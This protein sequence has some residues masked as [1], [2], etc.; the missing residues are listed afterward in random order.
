MPIG[1]QSDRFDG[2]RPVVRPSRILLL[3]GAT[4]IIALCAAAAWMIWQFRVQEIRDA[5]RELITLDILLIEESERALQSVDL[6]LQSLQ[7]KITSDGVTT[8][9]DYVSTQSG[10]DTHELLRSKITGIPQIRALALIGADGYIINS[11]RDEPVTDTNVSGR[12]YFMALR[13]ASTDMPYLGDL[14]PAR[15]AETWSMFLA[16]RV[17]APDGTFLGVVRSSIDVGYFEN[18]Y[19]ALEIGDGAAVSLWRIDGTLLARYPP[20]VGGARS[21]PSET[22]A[23]HQRLGIPQTYTVEHSSGDGLARLF[24]TVTAKQF[25]VVISVGQTFDNILKDWSH[26]ATLTLASALACIAAII[27]SLWLLA[28]Q[29]VAYEALHVAMEQ[30]EAAETA[31]LEVE[32][33]LR[34]AQKLEA[35]GQ[36]TGGIAHDFNNLLTAV[37]GNLELLTKHTAGADPRLPRWAKSAFDAAKRGAMLTQHLLAFS[38]RQPLDPKPADIVQLLHSILE[39]LRRTL[40]ENIEIK[41]MVAEGLWTAFVDVNQLDSALLNI[42]INARDA[43]E[44]QGHLLIEAHNVAIDAEAATQLDIKSG[45]YILISVSDTGKGIAKDVLDRVFEPFFTTKP[46]GQG[47]GLGLSQVYGFLKQ[48][49][50]QITIESQLGH[51]TAVKMYLP[52]ASCDAAAVT[53]LDLLDERAPDKGSVIL[54]VEDEEE[55]RSYMVETLA[56]FGHVVRQACDAKEALDILRQDQTIELLLTDIGLPGLNGREL[57]KQASI[58]RPDLKILFASGYARQAIMQNDRLEEGVELLVKP[59]TREQLAQKVRLVL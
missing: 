46:I 45:D 9:E 5:K 10:R 8:S 14:A 2:H 37:M 42:A 30:R 28:R 47:T 16:R 34:Q 18:L 59:F 58:L 20:V 51:G 21:F 17:S 22:I 31:R 36:L 44:G 40:G 13:D 43:M 15:G 3:I 35:I 11:S 48:T 52:R 23:A 50:G 26:I 24:A 6:V 49:G 32:E 54:V 25:P 38:R 53:K 12:D 1:L 39:L 4:T 33:Q 29:F 56:S 55:V 27:L 57:A 7:E 19:K 41:T